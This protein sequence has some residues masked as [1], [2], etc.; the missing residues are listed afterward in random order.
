VKPLAVVPGRASAADLEGRILCHDIRDGDGRVAGRKGQTLDSEAARRLLG[1]PVEEIHVLELEPG[2]LHE[3]PAGER[4][5]R[6]AAGEGVE[7]TGYSGG[8]WT[9]ASTR[10]GLL[11]VREPALSK[12]NA[13]PGVAVY[14]LYDLQPVERGEAVARAKVTPLALAESTVKQ[15]E[16]TARGAGGLLAVAAFRPALIGAVARENLDEAQRQ[17]F[18]RALGEKVEWFGSRLLPLRYCLGDARRVAAEIEAVLDAGADAVV[19][20]GASALDPLDPVFL[21]I[22][23][24]GGRMVRVGVPAHPGSLLFLAWRGDRPIVGMPTC[25]MFSQATTFDL[26]L[27]RLLAGERLGP[28]DLAGLGHGGLLSQDSTW[29]FP[30]Y[31]KAAVRGALPE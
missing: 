23:Y 14:S 2:D 3:E 25:G 31:R 4:I 20:A 9:L 26:V 22:G 8:Q 30:A 19:V 6:A 12:V 18:E 27:P 17:R 16:T 5:A 11:R 10:R 7:V 1:C 29:R 28:D 21:G 13:Q 15:V 24:A